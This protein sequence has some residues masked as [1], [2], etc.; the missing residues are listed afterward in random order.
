MRLTGEREVGSVLL[1]LSS[2]M[3]EF[4]Y[5]ETF[6]NAFDVSNKVIEL[7]MMDMGTDVCCTS[8]EDK[9]RLDSVK[10]AL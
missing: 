3:L 8:E 5:R 7:L 1:A 10:Q 2:R 6:V 9:T 4:N